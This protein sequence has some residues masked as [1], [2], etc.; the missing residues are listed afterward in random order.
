MNDDLPITMVPLAKLRVPGPDDWPS[1]LPLPPDELLASSWSGHTPSDLIFTGEKLLVMAKTY[2]SAKSA[3]YVHYEVMCLKDG[4]S[5]YSKR[6]FAP[7]AVGFALDQLLKPYGLTAGDL[8]WQQTNE[9]PPDAEHK[10]PERLAS[11]YFIQAVSGGLV[12]IGVTQY[13]VRHRLA[14]LQ[15]GSPVELRIVKTI[16]NVPRARETEIHQHFAAH[17]VRG[18]WFDPIVLTLELA[19]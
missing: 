11:V 4:V 12:K 18:E 6:P 17:R 10:H 7:W 19:A 5:T 14:S 16:D 13:D 2:P 15:T 1:T 3:G 8:E 9:I